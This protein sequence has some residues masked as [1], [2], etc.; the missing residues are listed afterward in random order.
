MIREISQRL[1]DVEREIEGNRRALA[2]IGVTYDDN[3]FDPAVALGK[4]SEERWYK[5]SET[6][7]DN[8]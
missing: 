2:E 7:V 6:D 1:A 5:L 4:Y 3:W 8:G